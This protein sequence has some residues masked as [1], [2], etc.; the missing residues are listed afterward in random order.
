MMA[1]TFATHARGFMRPCKRNTQTH[2]PM[3]KHLHV[4]S[5]EYAQSMHRYDKFVLAGEHAS[6]AI[7][8]TACVRADAASEGGLEGSARRRGTHGPRVSAFEQQF[9]GRLPPVGNACGCATHD[10]EK[11][12][13]PDNA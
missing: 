7:N 5:N 3:H 12:S 2:T 6:G 1:I 13:K 8:H 9:D 4:H 10:P 11:K